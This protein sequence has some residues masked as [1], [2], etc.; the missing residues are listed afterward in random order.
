MAEPLLNTTNVLTVTEVTQL[1]RDALER[2]PM[3]QMCSVVGEL[4]NFKRHTSGHLYFTLKDEKS[5]LRGIMFASR[6]R[7]LT[8]IP[9]DGMRV[10]VRGAIRV[11]E[12]DGQYQVYVDDMQ[13]DG[14]GA[15]YV[16]F[17]QLKERL[18]REGLFRSDRKRPL[19]RH[20][21][22]VGVVTS[23]TGAVIR[24][25]CSTLE[26]RYPLAKV[27]LSPALVQG[28]TAAASIVQAL[29]RLLEWSDTHERIDVIIVARGGGSLEELWPFNEEVVARA[30]AGCPIP[31][32]SAVGHETDYT[33]CDFAADVRAPTPTAAAEMVAPHVLDLRQQLQQ[34]E[35][36]GLAAVRHRLAAH[37]Q[38]LAAASGA[39]VLKRP[40]NVL[41]AYRQHV[42]F[43]ASQLQQFATRPIARGR[44]GFAELTERLH[45]VN[46]K[47][48]IGAMRNELAR[49]QARSEQAVR[50][51]VA[52]R[53]N[54]LDR[55]IVSLEALNP[56][57]VL[58][59]G[60][61]VV[62]A[63]DGERVIASASQVMAGDRIRI[64]MA[65]GEVTATVDSGEADV[66]ERG[67]QSRLDL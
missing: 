27:I 63:A 65:D 10:I 25:I 34:W 17:T 28:P 26:R 37:R 48:R 46:V 64:R 53:N 54:A 42:E 60:Y 33:I 52:R 18:E 29:R 61:S 39:A 41:N 36:R 11:F 50:L 58:R 22:R 3:L 44:R 13:P 6:A 40:A 15:L 56:L 43:L 7:N 4:S 59:R 31:V 19:P 5:R 57:S 55:A 8:F 49:H 32:V 30:V 20:P 9:E 16:A 24:D 47:T 12:R 21:R 62:Y 2:H 1:I 66:Y 38:R 35:S 45:R 14:I 23:P 67:V 51:Y